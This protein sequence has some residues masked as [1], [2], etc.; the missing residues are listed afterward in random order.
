MSVGCITLLHSVGQVP[1]NMLQAVSMRLLKC[2]MDAD[3]QRI[4]DPS[5]LRMRP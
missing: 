2:S 1:S 3:L 5:S 4:N